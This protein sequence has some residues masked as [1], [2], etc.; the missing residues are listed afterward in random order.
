MSRMPAYY[1]TQFPFVEINSTFYRT[2]SPGQLTRLAN[3]TSRGLQFSL[4]VP[5]TASHEKSVRD[6]RPFRQAADELAARHALV[7]FVLQFPETFRDTAGNRRWIDRVAGALRPYTTWVEFRHV[8]WNRPKLGEWLRE[9]GMELVAVDVPD[10]PQLF[11][12]GIIDSGSRHIYARL[13]SRQAELWTRHGAARY[14]YDYSDDELR[15]WLTRLVPLAD[16]LIDVHFVFNNCHRTQGIQ[17]A[18]RM[19]ELIHAEYPAFRVVEPPAPAPPI[20]GTL[21]EEAAA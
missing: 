9:R 3:R 18:R 16:E 21:F 5:R 12:R 13:H 17:N 7:G 2:P 15:E 4:K 19:A 1:A 20:Q 11:P 14:D 8:S 10:L 6:L